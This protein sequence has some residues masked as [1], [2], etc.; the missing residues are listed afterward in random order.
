MKWLVATISSFSFM[1]VLHSGHSVFPLDIN[2]ILYPLP[3]F[4]FF[5][6]LISRDG[7]SLQDQ[8]SSTDLNKQA[9][10]ESGTQFSRR[11]LWF[12]AFCRNLPSKQRVAGS[13]PAGRPICSKQLR[14]FFFKKRQILCR[15]FCGRSNP[16]RF[17][18]MYF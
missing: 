1:S 2:A 10:A 7:Q 12:P 8:H 16:P 13:S 5:S 11:D 18:R 6:E 4:S 17:S 15:Q 3:C 9:T 14:A